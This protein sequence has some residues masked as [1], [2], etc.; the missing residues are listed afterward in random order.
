MTAADM[1]AASGT[2]RYFDAVLFDFGRTLF[3]PSGGAESCV[4]FAAAQGV[5]VDV[6]T[7]RA[8]VAAA[9]ERAVTPEEIA[10]GRDL[11]PEQHR[12]CW[13][14]LYARLD[15][16]APGMAAHQYER[17]VSPEGWQVFAGAEAVLETLHHAG[18]RLAI[19][20]DVAFDLRPIVAAAGFDKWVSAYVFSY[21]VGVTKPDPK[22]FERACADLGVP[23]DLALM[24]GDSAAADGGAAAF[25]M[26]ALL[27]PQRPHDEPSGLDLVL[28]AVL[29]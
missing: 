9:W 4:A 21:E 6:E 20:S 11:G 15:E 14:D 18:V 26:P 27:L 8:E 19:V 17:E 12:T 10:K 7:V 3:A 28:R 1:T 23:P 25:G 29:G 22:M 13:L 24:V 2:G 5:D 16:L